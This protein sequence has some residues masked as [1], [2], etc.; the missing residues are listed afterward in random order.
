MDE[1]EVAIYDNG[2]GRWQYEDE[3]PVRRTE[4]K[5]FY[6][7]TGLTSTSPWGSLGEDSPGRQK[8]SSTFKHPSVKRQIPGSFIFLPNPD[9]KEFLAFTT[10]PLEEDITIKGPVSMTLYASTTEKRPS[11]WAFFI[12]IGE[13]GPDG[14]ALNPVTGKPFLRPDWTDAWT[15]KE[16]T[17]GAMETSRQNSEGSMNQDQSREIHGILLLT[18]K[19]LSRIPY[20]N[21]RSSLYPFLIHLKRDIKYGCR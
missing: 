3:Y 9:N 16:L 14:S 15:P 13:I 4:W 18:L 7:G 10:P 8:D 6:I 19:F 11:D 20:M 12:K 2:T 1:P 5:R 21:F 17:C